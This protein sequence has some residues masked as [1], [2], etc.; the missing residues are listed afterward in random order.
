MAAGVLEI[1]YALEETPETVI[2]KAAKAF[3]R[4]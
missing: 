2:Q 3:E 1:H 4:F